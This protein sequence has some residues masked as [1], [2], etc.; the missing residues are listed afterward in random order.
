MREKINSF[1][2]GGVGR[3]KSFQTLVLR[4]LPRFKSGLESLG[5]CPRPPHGEGIKRGEASWRGE[6]D[7]SGGTGVQAGMVFGSLL[8]SLEVAGDAHASVCFSVLLTW[9][10]ER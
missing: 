6:M 3:I 5:K 8:S 9:G 1:D 7:G 2:G 10:V 4:K